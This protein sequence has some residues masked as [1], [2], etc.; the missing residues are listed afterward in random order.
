M[1]T[2]THT[3]QIPVNETYDL[4]VVGGGVAGA[5][6]AIAGARRGLKTLLAEKSV[7]LG[8]LATLGHIAIYLPLCDGLGKKL[9]GGLAEELL[10]LSIRDSYNNLPE[11]WKQKPAVTAPEGGRYRT[12]FNAPAFAAA[13]DGAILGAG[14]DLLLDTSLGGVVS[15]DGHIR[16][17]LLDNRSGRTA[18][19]AKTVVDATGD[20]FAA[21]LAGA[22]TQNGTNYLCYWGYYTDEASIAEAA[23]SRDVFKAVKMFMWGDCKGETQPNDMP[24]VSGTRAEEITAFVL[25]GRAEALRQ[26]QARN[27]KEFAFTGFP[28]MP[29]LR[30]ARMIKGD[31]ALAYADSGVRFTDSIGCCG[32]WRKAGVPF[33]V[34]YR[35]LTV[36]GYDNL[37]T[38]GRAV[39]CADAEAW[40]VT[41]VIPVAAETGEAAGIAAALAG[42]GDVHCIA[43]PSLQREMAAG[44]T[45]IHL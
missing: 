39:S 3:E 9:I 41:R 20:A 13:L 4:V 5:A 15:Q 18:Y 38:V 31:Y 28:G 6:A 37:L 7:L 11:R 42:G 2:I 34:P 30:T 43:I 35:A 21:H 23:E 10:W 22:P 45:V 40:E 8:G 16:Y 12:T 33:E 1:K 26:L 44:G 25:R 17:L 27:P 36:P 24:L 14:V 32:D 19:A 29:Q